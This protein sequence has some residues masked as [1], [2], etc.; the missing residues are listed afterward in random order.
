[1]IEIYLCDNEPVWL[2]R[3]E[4][5]INDFQVKSDWEITVACRAKAPRE[6]LSAL[7]SRNTKNGIYFLEV[8]YTQDMN[9]LEMGA[10]IRKLDKNAFLIYVTAYEEMALEAF[11]LKLMALDYI[12]KDSC[13]FR[14]RICQCLEYVE[15]QYFSAQ[16][17]EAE[18]I[19]LSA[20]ASHKIF[21]K[22]D[23][24]YIESL[25]GSH[26]VILHTHSEVH[27]FPSS[28]RECSSKLQES[29][30]LCRRGCLVN[31]R[32]LHSADSKERRLLLD[33]GEYCRCSVRQWSTLS[34]LL[35]RPI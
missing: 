18:S 22:S 34:L 24:Y 7:R 19:V 33:N 31:L 10:E 4:Q 35:K 14:E 3:T 13:N 8:K 26:H 6:L 29:F 20:G 1:M 17:S 27:R 15:Q 11:R 9:G 25:K 30:F 28:L 21:L 32:H 2:K 12:I 5:A 23:I 16:N